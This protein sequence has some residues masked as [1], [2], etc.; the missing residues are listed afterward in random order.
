MPK[1]PKK[2]DADIL[3][4]TGKKIH[5]MGRDYTIKPFVLRNR[6]VVI[7]LFIDIISGLAAK[8]PKVFSAG[9]TAVGIAFIE[10]AGE[11]MIELYKIVLDENE[12]FILNN[13]TMKEEVVIVQ[14]VMEVND[15]DF[16][17]KE[18]SRMMPKKEPES[19]S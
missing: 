10:S 3:L 12:D 17:V 4:Q 2:D 19:Q 8:N 6:L 7:K 5:I 15:M 1:K 14:S 18:I 16:L 11:R 13:L 9:Q